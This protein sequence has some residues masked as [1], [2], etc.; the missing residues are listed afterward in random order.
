MNPILAAFQYFLIG[1]QSFLFLVKE[2]PFFQYGMILFLFGGIFLLFRRLFIV[3]RSGG[4]F[5]M[6]YHI[7]N[8]NFYIHSALIPGKRIIPIKEIT[9]KIGRA[10]CRERV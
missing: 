4:K 6:P 5:F 2:L 1:F 7:A 3:R 8:E 10:S 9:T